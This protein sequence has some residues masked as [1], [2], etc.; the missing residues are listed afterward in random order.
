[1]DAKLQIK[2]EPAGENSP[3]VKSDGR[4]GVKLLYKISV[5]LWASL[6]AMLPFLGRGVLLLESLK[7]P[8]RLL[9]FKLNEKS[10][11]HLYKYLFRNWLQTFER[12]RSPIVCKYRR[13]LITN[14]LKLCFWP[15]PRTL[16]RSPFQKKSPEMWYFVH[17]HYKPKT[18]Q[19]KL[20]SKSK[21]LTAVTILMKLKCFFFFLLC[22]T[23]SCIWM[24][25]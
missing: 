2:L 21:E 18:L 3:F 14:I 1:M 7:S 17:I 13:G 10:G 25:R 11:E 22:S 6:I 9:T 20:H 12:L 24:A 19:Q 5:I 23:W 15:W 8:S 16:L 4:K